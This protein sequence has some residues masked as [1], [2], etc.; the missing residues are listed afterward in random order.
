MVST[1]PNC[2][3]PNASYLPRVQGD[4]KFSIH[5]EVEE[6][7]IYYEYQHSHRE[8]PF[9]HLIDNQNQQSQ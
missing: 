5:I 7:Y 9:Q 1:T 6:A 4:Q 2:N 8:N 3:F